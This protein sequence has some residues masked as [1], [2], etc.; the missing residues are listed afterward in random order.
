P[1]L[2]RIRRRFVVLVTEALLGPRVLSSTAKREEETELVLFEA[3][4]SAEE[5]AAERVPGLVAD[6]VAAALLSVLL[7]SRLPGSFVAVGLVVL[8][9]A[10]LAAEAARRIAT[11]EA[12]RSWDTF[13]PLASSVEACIHGSLE[14]VGNGRDRAQRGLVRARTEAWV[15]RA[16]RADWL[17]G[18]SGRV[19]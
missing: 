4:W 18:L 19:P 10:A 7:V 6:V 1:L 15:R 8:A 16:W 17:A 3:L 14:L 2:A 9:F 5:L 13:L 12:Q 11:K